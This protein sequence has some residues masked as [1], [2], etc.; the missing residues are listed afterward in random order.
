L[1]LLALALIVVVAGACTSDN[2]DDGDSADVVLEVLSLDPTAVTAQPETGTGSCSFS[3][4][5]CTVNSDCPLGESCTGATGCQLTVE[6]WQITFQALPKNAVAT[7]SPY[8]DVV[9]QNVEITYTWQ[10]PGPAIPGQSVGLNGIT[11]PVNGQAQASFQPISAAAV[12]ND[13]TLEGNTADM[14]M[15]FRG[16]TVDGSGVSVVA[17]G[18][19]NIERCPLVGP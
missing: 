2:L 10:I 12:A 9:M 18:Q 3:G 16:R 13:P 1:G 8:N 6:D 14:V 17:Q 7:T 5:Q 19:L 11:V 15:V 4:A